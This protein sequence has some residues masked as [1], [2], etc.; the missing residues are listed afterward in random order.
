M[1]DIAPISHGPVVPNE[2]TAPSHARLDVSPTTSPPDRMLRSN[3]PADSVEVS[4]HA[5]LLNK[6]RELPDVRHSRVQAIREAISEGSYETEARLQAALDG[7]ITD[8][9]DL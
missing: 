4:D 6:L 9:E 1:P 7:I 3:E 5:R 2:R 8:I